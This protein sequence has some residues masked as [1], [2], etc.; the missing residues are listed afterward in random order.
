MLDKIFMKVPKLNETFPALKN[1]CLHAC[2]IKKKNGN[3]GENVGK[4]RLEGGGERIV[5]IL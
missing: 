4:H 5:K 1:L 3:T 2:L